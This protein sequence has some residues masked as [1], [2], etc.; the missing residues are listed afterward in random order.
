MNMAQIFESLFLADLENFFFE[1]TFI[2][3]ISLYRFPKFCVLIMNSFEKLTTVIQLTAIL[4][5]IGLCKLILM[6]IIT[7]SLKTERIRNQQQLIE[8][9]KRDFC[10]YRC[11]RIVQN[12]KNT[13]ERRFTTDL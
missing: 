13:F 7:S 1:L 3:E 5:S 9:S 12:S 11:L 6:R 4:R 2:Q 10:C 8:K